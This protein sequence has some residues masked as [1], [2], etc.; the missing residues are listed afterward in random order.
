MS[1]FNADE[2]TSTFMTA[3]KRGNEVAYA[4]GAVGK[5]AECAL[6]L[7]KKKNPKVVVGALRT[8]VKAK[9]VSYGWVSVEGK[10]ARFRA[11]NPF[12][13]MIKQLRLRFRDE[14]INAFRPV[15]VGDDGHEID[16]ESLPEDQDADEAPASADLAIFGRVADAWAKQEKAVKT[17][18]AALARAIA[19]HEEDPDAKTAARVVAQFAKDWPEGLADG[20]RSAGNG[21]G[22]A[23][24]SAAFK[25][26]VAHLQ[27]HK[28]LVEIC[29]Q[30]VFGID[31]DLTRQTATLLKAVRRAID[32]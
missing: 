22:N 9:K 17:Q 13:G 32:G 23:A 5:P 15:L 7:D 6:L 14:K 31:V 10:T 2:I 21:D 16:E 20:L 30:N 26:I 12:K 8:Q 29:E 1:A 11:I 28:S 25:K 19:A 3:R 4:F 27:G 18:L 24:A